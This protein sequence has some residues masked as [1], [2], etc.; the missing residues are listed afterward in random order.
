MQNI[1]V[2][3]LADDI[4]ETTRAT[5]LNISIPTYKRLNIIHKNGFRTILNF[6]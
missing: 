4:N 1:V 3:R 2:L 5:S 6:I